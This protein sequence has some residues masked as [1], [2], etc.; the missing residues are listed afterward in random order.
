LKLRC[1]ADVAISF[2][3]D[4]EKSTL[5]HVLWVD[6][7]I[8]TEAWRLFK[9]FHDKE[10]SFTDCTSFALMESHAIKTAFTFDNHFRQHGLNTLP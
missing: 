4:L 10:Y 7:E 8:E 9:T 2:R 3:K 1:G 6:S 5:V